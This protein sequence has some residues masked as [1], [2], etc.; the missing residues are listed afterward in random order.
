MYP[1]RRKKIRCCACLLWLIQPQSPTHTPTLSLAPW[2]SKGRL[3]RFAH[4]PIHRN[5]RSKECSHLSG[6][7]PVFPWGSRA[8][9]RPLCRHICPHGFGRPHTCPTRIQHN[10]THSAAPV[11]CFALS[12]LVALRSVLIP[13]VLRPHSVSSAFPRP[14]GTFAHHS[15]VGLS[16]CRSDIGRA[17]RFRSLALAQ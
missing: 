11:P 7:C 4:S 12:S 15:A 13:S 16:F 9:T 8:P 5:P 10:R 2:A 3:V 17:V 1:S 6:C 14:R